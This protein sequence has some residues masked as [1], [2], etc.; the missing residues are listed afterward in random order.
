MP[1]LSEVT[2][3][4]FAGD[5]LRLSHNYDLGQGS[6]PV[7]LIVFDPG[8]DDAGMGLLVVSGYKSGKTLSIF[9]LASLPQGARAISR[10]WLID[11]WNDWFRY[12]YNPNVDN[13]A[14]IPIAGTRV[15]HWDERQILEIA[16]ADSRPA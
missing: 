14:P 2:S 11:N 5:L 3:D 4:L 16:S 6:G 1:L 7:D 13:A 10:Q 12:T 8:Q 15:L 9:P